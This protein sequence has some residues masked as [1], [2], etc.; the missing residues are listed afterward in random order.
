M[1]ILFLASCTEAT[2]R[3]PKPHTYPR[4]EFPKKSYISY[5]NDLCPFTFQVPTYSI[6]KKDEYFF[7]QKLN[8][9]C[10]FDIVFP[11]FN[12]VIHC[13]YYSIANRR[14]FDE[15]VSD[16]FELVG[17]HTVKANFRDD[18][19]IEKPNNVSGIIFEIDGN[20]ATPMQFYLTD[21]TSHFFR[22]ALYFNNKVAPD[23]MA[24]IHEFIKKDIATLIE[25]FEWIGN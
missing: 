6:V 23:S 3:V 18:L 24:I 8:N 19:I 2:V 9:P 4:V 11:S 14:Q 15:L 5:H 21:S 1:G 20:V 13:S 16:A 10:W 17:K 12:G 25:G 22:G 7:D